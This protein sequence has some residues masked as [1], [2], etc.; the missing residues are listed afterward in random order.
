MK[1]VKL[2]HSFYSDHA[3]LHNAMDNYDG[4][5]DALKTRGY[6]V[7]VV[8]IN[9]LLFAIPLRSRI[10]HNGAYIT[11]HINHKG[12]VGKGLDFSKALLITDRKY[13]STEVFKIDPVQH[14]KIR[15]KGIHIRKAFEKYVEKYIEASTKGDENILNSSKYKFTTLINYHPEL[16]IDHN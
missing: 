14:K 8:T 9:T 2:D 3:H 4:N 7:A 15:E 12:V 10:R 13:L 5:W 16:G 6:G 11:K 1:T